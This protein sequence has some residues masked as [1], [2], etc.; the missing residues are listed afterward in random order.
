MISKDIKL[1]NKEM[2]SEMFKTNRD[3]INEYYNI[4]V[5]ILGMNNRNNA[6][7]TIDFLKTFDGYISSV[8]LTKNG[9]KKISKNSFKVFCDDIKWI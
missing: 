3:R 8:E 7:R 6:E 5:K 9:Y 1:E 4:F 2:I